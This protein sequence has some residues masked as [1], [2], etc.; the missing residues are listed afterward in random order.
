MI[1]N[2]V[3]CL[4]L[5]VVLA[6][7][8][9]L[10]YRLARRVF[11]LVLCHN[12]VWAGALTLIATNLIAYK[13]AA[14]VAWV[15]LGTGLV[16]F[17]L[18]AWLVSYLLGRRD[19]RP[20]P[21]RRH[22]WLAGSISFAATRPVFYVALGLY[23]VAF[24]VYLATVQVRFGLTTLL[25][26]PA[27]IR[28]AHGESYLESVPLPARLLLYL[29]PLLFVFLVYRPAIDRPFPL[30][31]RI[32][33]AIVLAGTMLA[34]LQRTNIF[35]AMLLWAAAL[36]SQRW[37]ARR[38]ELPVD[39][40]RTLR[41]RWNVL[42][43]G[44]RVGGGV[45]ALGL[46]ALLVFQGIGG[47]LNKTGQES[48]RSGTVASALARSGLTAPYQYYT[49]GT[50]AFL[51]LA[52]SDNHEAPPER[53]R[54][55]FVVGDWNPQTWGA[56]TFSSVL[57]VIPGI[58]HVDPISAFIDTGVPTNVFT[59]L[60][61]F[62]RDFRLPGVLVATALMG[63]G[64]GW[65]FIRRFRSQTVFWISCVCLT[66]VFLAP[67][68]TRITSTPVISFIIF[69]AAITL[70]SRWTTYRATRGRVQADEVS[71]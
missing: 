45:V 56:S 14:A 57:R 43:I 40:K 7:L 6:A 26:H 33:G 46:V 51:Q 70:A 22:G 18:G 9:V 11:L 25:L 12:L 36:I 59:W 15:T 28:S 17:N 44:W 71:L 69:S 23:G 27:V 42:P 4:I 35:F 32:V 8:S 13:T 49:A 34:L 37:T 5:L 47:A 67:F 21:E 38:A 50:M 53:V 30:A 65:L 24:A 54:G 2:V 52:G 61:P 62:Y 3:W 1:P 16:A 58:P 41:H 39:G 64:F 66:T 68:A 63:A 10:V 55:V 29:G 19:A 31:L 20:A 60:E 48:L